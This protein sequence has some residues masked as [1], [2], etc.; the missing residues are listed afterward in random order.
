MIITIP[1]TSNTEGHLKRETKSG[2]HDNHGNW[3]KFAHIQT[4]PHIWN[5]KVAV[6]SDSMQLLSWCGYSFCLP[7]SALL[8]WESIATRINATV[9]KEELE[10][11]VLISFGL[12]YSG[13]Q[14]PILCEQEGSTHRQRPH[15][16]SRKIW[17]STAASYFSILSVWFY[18]RDHQ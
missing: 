15:H 17:P 16:L 5:D 6:F 9:T 10:I 14:W 4:K 11:T 1:H 8:F 2:K 12:H 7:F 18:L 3:C 13:C